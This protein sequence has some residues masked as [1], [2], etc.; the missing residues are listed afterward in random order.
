MR[1]EV[2][3]EKNVD[4]PRFHHRIHGPANPEFHIEDGAARRRR[5]KL[6]TFNVE[7]DLHE[8]APLLDGYDPAHHPIFLQSL[9]RASEE[10]DVLGANTYVAPGTRPCRTGAPECHLAD[11]DF[12]RTL[13]I[14]DCL[15]GK[16]R[17]HSGYLGH[18]PRPRPFPYG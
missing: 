13:S 12:C 4:V 9:T 1:P 5:R 14:G 18:L 6:T 8:G 16:N 7:H 15:A 10:M 17:L 11:P 3:G 2:V